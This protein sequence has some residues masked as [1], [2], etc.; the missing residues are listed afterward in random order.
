MIRSWLPFQQH[1]SLHSFIW[2][3]WSAFHHTYNKYKTIHNRT[4]P[5]HIPTSHVQ[6][7]NI[8]RKF[9]DKIC[10]FPKC[11]QNESFFSTSPNYSPI[12][13]KNTHFE[14]ILGK[15]WFLPRNFPM[16]FPSVCLAKT[17]LQTT[18]LIKSNRVSQM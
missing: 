11:S 4:S 7:G 14:N 3:M 13:R 12:L 1:K 16:I 6:L 9:P 15:Y 10:I 17:T 8:V 18:P 5:A 2:R